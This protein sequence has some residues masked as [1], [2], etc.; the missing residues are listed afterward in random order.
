M[1]EMCL[2]FNNKLMRIS[3]HITYRNT[4]TYIQKRFLVSFQCLVT[5]VVGMEV[6][7]TVPAATIDIAGRTAYDAS[8][9]SGI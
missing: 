2:S 5:D 3:L 9:T 7:H 4:G 8:L 6:G 1:L